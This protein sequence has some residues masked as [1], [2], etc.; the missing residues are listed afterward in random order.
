MYRICAILGKPPSTWQEG[1]QM[2]VN[3]G[4]VFPKFSACDLSKIVARASSSAIDLIQKMLIWDPHYR[5]SARDCLNH[6]YF[7]DLRGVS[8]QIEKQVDQVPNYIGP[9]T[10]SQNLNNR[11]K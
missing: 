6:P 11:N 10:D 4:T 1:Y 7:S 8:A 3:I 2:A 5:P 9:N